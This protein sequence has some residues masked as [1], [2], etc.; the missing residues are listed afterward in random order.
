MDCYMQLVGEL[1]YSTGWSL[2]KCNLSVYVEINGDIF[3]LLLRL[4][5]RPA[6]KPSLNA[7]IAFSLAS[8]L[9][10]TSRGPHRIKFMF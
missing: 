2:A 6:A 5:P 3:S 4:S 10:E 8:S 9:T 1:R 7:A